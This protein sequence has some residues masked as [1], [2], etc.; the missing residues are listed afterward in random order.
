MVDMKHGVRSIRSILTITSLALLLLLVPIAFVSADT[1]PVPS[2]PTPPSTVSNGKDYVQ[3]LQEVFK[4]VEQNYVDKPDPKK[5]FEGAMKGLFDTLKDPHSYYLSQELVK[6][7]TDTTRGR[8]GGV[9]L[10]ISKRAPDANS[11]AN[12]AKSQPNASDYVEV[13][14]PIQGTPAYKAGISAGDRI[15]KIDGE[16]TEPM[17]IDEVVNK[18]RG[19]PGT[20]V[21]VTVLRADNITFDAD[22]VRGIIDVPVVKDAMIPP[23]IGY[24]RIAEYTPLTAPKVKDAVEKLRKDGATSF[25]IDERGNPGGLL[26]AVVST[27]DFFLSSGVIVS[28]RSRIPSDNEV[29]SAHRETLI[30][31]S[32][33]IIILIDRN[34]ASAA[35]IFAGALKDHKRA[36]L[37]GETSF[38]KGSVQQVFFLPGGDGAYKLTTAKYYTPNGKNIDKIGI[39]PDIVVKEPELTKLEQEDLQKL[40]NDNSIVTFVRENPNADE[41]KVTAF[42]SKLHDEGISLDD[43]ILKRLIRNEQD[44]MQNNPPAYDLTYDTVLK[45]AVKLLKTGQYPGGGSNN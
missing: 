17:T 32:V 10:I 6:D 27:S 22:L 43:T 18:L 15:T 7:F 12:G 23:N 34:S 8:F 2:P 30:P 40:I 36:L 28:T 9:G 3:L 45:E 24:I 44:R 4:S 33:P 37:V 13:V 25:I 1:K 39:K 29:F 19:V 21:T 14:S 38:G 35:E 20:K 26:T 31:S 42:I 16:S 41:A 11:S 5:L